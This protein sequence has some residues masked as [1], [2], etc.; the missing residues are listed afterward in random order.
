MHVL[1]GFKGKQALLFCSNNNSRAQSITDLCRILG[2]F[3]VFRDCFALFLVC[4]PQIDCKTL[5]IIF[6]CYF[7]EIKYAKKNK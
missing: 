3:L 2:L 6:L 1:L 5:F 4:D 7:R